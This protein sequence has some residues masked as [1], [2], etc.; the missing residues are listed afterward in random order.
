MPSA[1]QCLSLRLG[2]H[3]GVDTER[4]S[5]PLG[6]GQ[7]PHLVSWLCLLI[8]LLGLAPPLR[9]PQVSGHFNLGATWL[10]SWP[11]LDVRRK[12]CPASSG[13]IVSICFRIRPVFICLR[14]QSPGE[15]IEI[16]ETTQEPT[17]AW[18]MCFCQFQKIL[19]PLFKQTREVTEVS[20]FIMEFLFCY[21]P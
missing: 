21:S 16:Y 19:L 17:A 3:M 10:T 20:D 7:T 8:S 5:E 15:R 13:L 18:L 9:S 14:G 6:G 1:C 11:L 2:D 4:P 12:P